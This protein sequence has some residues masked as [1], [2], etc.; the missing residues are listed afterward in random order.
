MCQ[1]PNFLSAEEA[2]TGPVRCELHLSMFEQVDRLRSDADQ[3]CAPEGSMGI[4]K[5][6]KL[7]A[8]SAGAVMHHNQQHPIAPL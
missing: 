4:P 8:S 6:I 5:A 7:R 2:G 1:V 3:T